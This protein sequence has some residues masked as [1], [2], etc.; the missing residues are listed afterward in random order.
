MNRHQVQ[1]GT[2]DAHNHQSHHHHRLTCT[3]SVCSSTCC[4]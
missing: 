1:A 3:I 2:S 4:Q